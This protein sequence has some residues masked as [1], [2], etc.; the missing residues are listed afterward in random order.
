MRFT[1]AC[2]VA[3]IMLN[4]EDEMKNLLKFAYVSI[5]SRVGLSKTSPVAL[6]THLQEDG[7]LVL[8]SV[9]E[10]LNPD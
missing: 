8:L 5:A 4:H 6:F 3:P 2:R 1:H 9:Y 10:L 7:G